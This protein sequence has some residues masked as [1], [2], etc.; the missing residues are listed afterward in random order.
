MVSVWTGRE[1]DAPEGDATHGREI[2]NRK[3]LHEP[4]AR[5]ELCIIFF[6]GN[7]LRGG[8]LTGNVSEMQSFVL[9]NAPMR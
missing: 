7:F 2:Y 6:A 5:G 8:H 9:C 4:A 3:I 1:R